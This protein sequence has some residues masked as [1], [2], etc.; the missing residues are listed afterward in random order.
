MIPRFFANAKRFRDSHGADNSRAWPAVFSQLLLERFP[1]HAV[2]SEREP[3]GQLDDARD[4]VLDTSVGI[5]GGSNLT[6]QGAGD[7]GRWGPMRF[8]GILDI[9]N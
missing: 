4:R 8:T 2:S 5:A 1:D 9:E 6:E 3:R 7:A